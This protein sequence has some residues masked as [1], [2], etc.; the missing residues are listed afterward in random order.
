MA[1]NFAAEHMQGY[2]NPELTFVSME[3]DPNAGNII[4]APDYDSVLAMLN[5]GCVPQLCVVRGVSKSVFA[6]YSADDG[7][8]IIFGNTGS[9]QVIF[10]KN[11][12]PVFVPASGGGNS[13]PTTTI[14]YIKRNETVLR[15]DDGTEITAQEAYNAFMN[16]R[17]LL[18]HRTVS[19]LKGSPISIV[20][21]IEWYD[22]NSTWNDPTNVGYVCMYYYNKSTNNTTTI[23]VGDISLKPE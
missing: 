15:H 23:E 2:N 7:G 6:F 5:R 22:N 21:N 18:Q 1:I 12:S 10:N 3:I 8:R 4:S 19:N 20:T 9:E 13:T 16:G 17:V 14:F 11:S